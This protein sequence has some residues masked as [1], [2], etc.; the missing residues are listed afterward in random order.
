MYMV[1]IMLPMG[2]YNIDVDL[3][4]VVIHDE[5]LLGICD[6]HIFSSTG[7]Y[8]C[9]FFCRLKGDSKWSEA[10]YTYLLAGRTRF[11]RLISHLFLII[12]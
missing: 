9:G 12:Y 11:F 6:K 8:R 7:F 1:A 5:A 10:Y 3:V 2:H 4:Y